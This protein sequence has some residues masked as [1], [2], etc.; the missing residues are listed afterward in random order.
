MKPIDRVLEALV[1]FGI[2]RSGEQ[3]KSLCPCHND[4]DPSLTIGI[5]AN[6]RVTLHCFANCRTEDILRVIGLVW[7][8][9][10]DQ[11]EAI[12]LAQLASLKR[13]PEQWLQDECGLR[14]LPNNQGVGMPYC[15]QKHRQLFM[16]RRVRLRAS[17]GGTRQPKG[18]SLQAYGQWRL[19]EARQE[20]KLVLVEGESDCWTLWHAGFH[21]LGL[22]GAAAA[23]TLEA[24]YLRGI[25]EVFVWQEPGNAGEEFVRKVGKRLRKIDWTGAAKLIRHADHK[26]PSALYIS[27]PEGF[28]AAFE[29]VLA[30]AGAIAEPAGTSRPV[31]G[32]VAAAISS[33][34]ET[35]AE[36]T[37]PGPSPGYYSLTDMGNAQ[38][39][40]YFC[41]KNLRWVKNWKSWLAW[42]N[43]LWVTNADNAA[44]RAAMN[45]IRAIYAESA[46]CDDPRMRQV[47]AEHAVASESARAVEAMVRLARPHPSLEILHD[48]LDLSPWL[49]G[50]PN[51]TVNLTTGGLTTSCREDMITKRCPTAFDPDAQCPVWEQFLQD[52][53]KQDASL[54]SYVQRLLGYCLTGNTSAHLLAV[55]W[56]GGGNGKSTLLNTFIRML[57]DNYAGVA[58]P[59]L[60]MKRR[61]ERHPT[62]IAALHGK[63]L[64]AC[65]ETEDGCRLNE[66]QVKSLTSG[67]VLTARRMREDFWD[68]KPTHKLILSTNYRP[69]VRG[70]D[71][72]L[73][74]RLRLIPFTVTFIGDKEDRT[75]PGRLIAEFPGILAWAVRGCLDWLHNGERMP[76]VVAMATMEY[77][78]GED[79]VGRF[80]TEECER[81]CDEDIKASDLYRAFCAWLERTGE[82]ARFSQKRFGDRLNDHGMERFASNGM[83]YRHIRLAAHAPTPSLNGHT[84][85][86]V[87][88]LSFLDD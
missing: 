2:Q 9:L 71:M 86:Q 5:G 48:V 43:G 12:T 76:D 15:D 40:I 70:N 13:L 54:I 20:R 30:G 50:C 11:E 59:D 6:N 34:P 47:L 67:D 66:S 52:I 29:A 24:D 65:Q 10:F 31:S 72:G 74:R 46:A 33:L 83:K 49:L 85:G 4:V 39:L 17:D 62:E 7:A 69:S 58:T 64:V 77:R 42:E 18:V 78:S 1:S 19:P 45:T 28:R 35:S 56:G 23:K 21:A 81:G 16:R 55:F 38:R 27:H 82:P 3:W 63:R 36:P 84:S 80:L 87:P 60:L 14:D 25:E 37:I 32:E 22:P 53:F 68:F 88:D 51:G 73:W 8:D 61:G 79:L 26:D 57:G 44:V 41:G 75:L